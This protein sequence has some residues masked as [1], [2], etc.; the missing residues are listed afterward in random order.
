MT[1]VD[2]NRLREQL[3]SRDTDAVRAFVA[4]MHPAD[5]AAVIQALS[6]REAKT[7]LHSLEGTMAS[8]VLVELD[9]DLRGELL[10]DVPAAEIVEKFI[11][12]MDSDDAADTIK[13]LPEDVREEVVALLEKS[14]EEDAQ[15][16][17]ELLEHPEDSAGG[18]MAK[19]LIQAQESETV[20]ECIAQIQQR[21]DEVG[22]IY[23][24]Y[25]TDKEDHLLG[26]V[27]LQDLVL[28]P[29]DTRLWKIYDSDVQYAYVD[30][31]AAEVAKVMQKYDLIY[32][33]VVDRNQR[34]VGRITV[35]DVL[36]FI[37][38]EAEEDYQ[39]ASGIS[40][41]VSHTD[42]VWVLS[43]ARIPWLLLGLA[44]GIVA[45]RVI[46]VHEASIQ[47]YPEMAFFIP[48]IT[49]MGGNAGIQSSALVVQALAG[50][51]LG[52][53]GFLAKIAKELAVALLN[54][55]L[56]GLI[57]LVYG[58]FFTDLLATALT[59]S[60]SLLSVILIASAFG[61]SIPLLLHKMGI[62]PALATGPFIT[63]SNDLIGL[64]VYFYIGHLLYGMAL[65]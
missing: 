16:V 12:P 41:D 4:E 35:D 30:T 20:A 40:S 13:E 25:V 3:K 14:P 37:K 18:L 56:C 58:L 5:I 36:D 43:R 8:D 17:I 22:D 57:L 32:L 21:K 33:P 42:R 26:V 19:E 47:V 54:G 38:D 10:E 15:D 23:A 28:Y 6:I 24:V 51:T 53:S 29:S 49:A 59:I 1:D 61:L 64:A 7:L 44:G 45:S 27:A 48:V 9:E 31:P 65:P 39:L 63:T 62:D 50:Q 52:E 60:L 11:E 55:L 46:S 2:L 34:L